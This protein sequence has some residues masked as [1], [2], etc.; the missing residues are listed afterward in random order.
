MPG[1]TEGVYNAQYNNSYI[2]TYSNGWPSAR[3]ATPYPILAV[4]PSAPSW[5]QTGDI[6][7]DQTAITTSGGSFWRSI[8]L[9][10]TC[11]S[12]E[13][14]T[15][16]Q[17]VTANRINYMRLQGDCAASTGAAIGVSVSSG[18]VGIAVYSNSGSSEAAVPGVQKA[19]TGS[20]TCPAAGMVKVPWIG[21]AV[22]VVEG[23]WLAFVCDDATTAKFW[24]Q[25]TLYPASAIANGLC[26]A[27]TG[28]STTP[29]ANATATFVSQAMWLG[30]V[31][32]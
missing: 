15:S 5:L 32:P 29:P 14:V 26:I 31:L 16:S 20:V 8:G 23:D 3:P 18:N 13:A 17:S 1:P 30:K 9:C 19:T 12:P 27:Q 2:V 28:S 4:G 10:R 24:R 6:F 7:A 11:G 21:G 22:D 25:G